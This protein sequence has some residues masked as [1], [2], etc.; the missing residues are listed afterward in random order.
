MRNSSD[1]LEAI[2]NFQKKTSDFIRATK[3]R[4]YIFEDRNV[5]EQLKL[6]FAIDKSHASLQF[7]QNIDSNEGV[8]GYVIRSRTPI[9]VEDIR[10]DSRFRSIQSEK[11]TYRT[12][13]CIIIPLQANSHI[14]G[15][16]TFAD[17]RNDDSFNDGDFKTALELS[18]VLG[19]LIANNQMK[20][21]ITAQSIAS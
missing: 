7:T 20:E 16:L 12:G 3:S 21:L 11:A 1:P 15:V 18:A 5:H 19:L 4:I 17:K 6:V 8:V 2:Q 10:S 13:S 14:M 9:L